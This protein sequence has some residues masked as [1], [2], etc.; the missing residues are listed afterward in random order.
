MFAIL[1]SASIVIG[2]FFSQFF[3]DFI[4]FFFHALFHR[5]ALPA[6][7]GKHKGEDPH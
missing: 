5:F 6:P 7:K 2:L 1:A 3:P 4:H